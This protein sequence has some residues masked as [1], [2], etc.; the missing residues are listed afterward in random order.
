MEGHAGFAADIIKGDVKSAKLEIQE[1]IRLIEGVLIGRHYADVPI[2]AQ[3]ICGI[4]PMVHNLTSIKAVEN[5][6]KVE[7][8]PETEM[9]RKLLE[10]AQII[11]SHALHIFFLSLA[12][13]LDIENDLKLVEDYPAETKKVVK[14]REFGMEIVKIIGGRV[15][16]PLTNEVGGFKKVPTLEEIQ[17]LIA[18]GEEILPIALE[19]AEFMKNIRLPEFS[20]VS[21]Y[22]CLDKKGE[23]A[24]YDGDV[25]SNKGLRIPVEKFEK[26]FHELQRPLEIIKRVESDRKT[27]YMVGAIARVNIHEDRLFPQAAKY[28]RQL[29]YKLPDY[30]SFHNVLYQMVEIIQGIEESDRIL[31]ALAHSD[32]NNALTKPYK[33]QEGTGVA[34]VEAPRGTLY[35][36][37]DIDEKGYVK[38]VNIITPTAQFLSHLEDDIAVYLPQVKD[39]PE[40]EREKKLRA[41]IRAYDPCIS[42]AVH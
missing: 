42:C 3:R 37:I 13:F 22:V 33:V 21:E 4:C 18:K 19:V 28:L 31:R 24:I 12:D 41:F 32:L 20:R 8:S 11:H 14:I 39:L 7:V 16:H 34:A 25:I 38:N 23:Y 1:G 29:N 40:H 35:Y 26:N 5:A 15:V 2:I 27:S 17:K 9:L 6:M 36:H 30:N 10:W